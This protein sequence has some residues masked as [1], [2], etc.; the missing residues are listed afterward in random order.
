M[1]WFLLDSPSCTEVAKGDFGQ[2]NFASV[3]EVFGSEL[4][5]IFKAFV[6][7]LD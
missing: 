6:E 1:Q 5:Q 7:I 3:R 2:V 4:S